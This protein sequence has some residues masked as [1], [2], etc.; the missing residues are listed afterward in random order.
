VRGKLHSNDEGWDRF[1][2][3]RGTEYWWENI[4][5][6]KAAVWNC[7]IKLNHISRVQPTRRN[8][9]YKLFYMFQ[10]VSPPIIR[11]TKLYIQRQVL[12]NQYYCLL[13]SRMSFISYTIA[14]GSSIGLKITDA[15]YTVLCSWWWAEEPSETCRLIEINRSRKRCV[16]LVVLWRYTCDAWTYER[17][18]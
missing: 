11:G 15:V 14:A 5:F 2:K 9:F 7:S 17:H 3:V 16:L 13:L 18:I 12:S 8:V 10:A 6:M 1:Y 4:T